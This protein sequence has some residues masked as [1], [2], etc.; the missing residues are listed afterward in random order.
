MEKMNIDQLL[1]AMSEEFG[2]EPETMKLLSRFYEKAVFEH[3]ANK[4]FAMA[5]DKIPPK[6]KLLLSFAIA[7]ALG[8]ERCIKTYARVAL[9]KGIAKDELAEALMVAR[10]VKAT[11]VFSDS[12][13]AMDFIVN[14]S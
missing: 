4:N 13:T 7:A 2:G 10:F 6:Y 14:Q 1:Q 8:S 12:T 11:T 3:A 9:K 5:G